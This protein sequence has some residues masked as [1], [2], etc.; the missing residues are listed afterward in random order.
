MNYPKSYIICATPRSG[1]TLLCDLLTDTGLAGKPDSF[2]QLQ[3]RQW[4]AK[5]LNVPSINWT[6]E[7]AFDRTFLEAIIQRGKSKTPVFG[8]RLMWSDLKA[9]N[10]RL[11]VLYPESSNNKGEI[12]N[13]FGPTLFI[14]LSRKDKVAQAVSRVKAEQSG[15]WHVDDKGNERE[16]LK[17][18][19]A[20]IYDA[21]V[22][23][24]Q[25]LEYEK[26]DLEWSHWFI[27]NKIQPVCISYEELSKNP[28]NVLKTILSALGQSTDIV[29]TI[30]PRTS[31]LADNKSKEW[32]KRFRTEEL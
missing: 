7:S 27:Q 24:N 21:A 13:V 18:G 25:I 17:L 10:K 6:N 15:L 19:K 5:R 11:K 32:I 29:G 9:L 2:F 20:L 14:H 28:Q 31:K 16:R 8:M 1:T 22:L 26:H 4:W 30:K 12:Q 23:S 3:S